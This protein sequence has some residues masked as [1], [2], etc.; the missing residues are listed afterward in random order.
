MTEARSWRLLGGCDGNARKCEFRTC[1]RLG[2]VC[3]LGSSDQPTGE[4]NDKEIV[5]ELASEEDEVARF[6]RSD[7]G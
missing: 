7:W 1:K 4:D 5:L 2:S 6:I 3:G